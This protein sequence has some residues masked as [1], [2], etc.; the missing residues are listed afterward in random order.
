MV[1]DGTKYTFGT[2]FRLAK[3]RIVSGVRFWHSCSVAEPV[4]V[5]LW[6]TSS[7]IAVTDASLSPGSSIRSVYFGTSSLDATHRF[8]GSNLRVSVMPQASPFRYARSNLDPNTP[9][10]PFLAGP[11]LVVVSIRKFLAGDS[12]P[13]GNATTEWYPIEPILAEVT[14]YITGTIR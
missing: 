2:E 3:G 14:T 12:N 1:S 10:V 9:T 7:R 11:E 4:R 6:T 13:T 5:S 8:G